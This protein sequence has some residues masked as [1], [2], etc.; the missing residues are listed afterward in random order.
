MTK[1]FSMILESGLPLFP[2]LMKPCPL[3]IFFNT[4][5]LIMRKLSLTLPLLDILS[6]FFSFLLFLKLGWPS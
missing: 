5:T 6:V 4:L 2:V 1:L 3:L